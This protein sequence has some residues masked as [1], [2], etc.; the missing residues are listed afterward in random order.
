MRLLS[1][2]HPLAN[3]APLSS[4]EGRQW[5]RAPATT[6]TRRR[7]HAPYSVPALAHAPTAGNVRLS[8][9]PRALI[10][11]HKGMRAEAKKK[12]GQNF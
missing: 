11:T 8:V 5:A 9:L 2:A 1:I 7:G 10:R 4:C 12:K 3:K 6:H